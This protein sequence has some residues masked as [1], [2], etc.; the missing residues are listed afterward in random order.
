MGVP[1]I[2][3]TRLR[4]VVKEK[5][6]KA[7]ESVAKLKKSAAFDSVSNRIPTYDAEQMEFGTFH[8]DEF[9]SLFADLRGSTLRA[10]S[11]GP[12]YT[13]LTI[14]AIIPALIYIVEKY[15]GYVIDLPGDGVMAL[16]KDNRNDIFWSNDKEKLNKEEL[17]YKCGFNIIK[18]T[19]KVVNPLLN[20]DGIAGLEVGVGIGSGMCVVTKV[21]T[22]RTY[23]T[24]AIGDCMNQSSKKSDGI[25]ELKISTSVYNRLTHNNRNEL[26]SIGNGWY[27]IKVN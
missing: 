16:F 11:L 3:E 23:D 25:D 9:V 24:K 12:E 2:E 13:F 8:H 27:S 6:D 1:V 22:D 15:G 14:H 10:Q 17:G 4:T 5:Y 7:K 20:E 19:Q 18:M 21:G 26:N